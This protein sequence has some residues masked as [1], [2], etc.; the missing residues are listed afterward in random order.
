MLL[1]DW[2]SLEAH[3]RGFR[4]SER[5]TQWKELLHHFYEQ[6]PVVKH[7]ASIEATGTAER[8]IT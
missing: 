3:T 5:Y 6:F 8:T 7:F 2:E 4:G 1:V